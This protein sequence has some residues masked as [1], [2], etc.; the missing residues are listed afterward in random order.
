M[1]ALDLSRFGLPIDA[2]MGELQAR[3]ARSNGN[4][5]ATYSGHDQYGLAFRFFIFDK[6]NKVKSQ[7]AGVELYDPI[8]MIEIFIDRKTRLHQ[9]V[10]DKIRYRHEEEYQRFKEGREAPGTP[11]DKWGVIPSHE[12]ATLVKAGIFSVEQLA[13]QSA[14]RIQGKFPA[15]FFEHFQRA[16]QFVAAKTGRVEAEKMADKMLELQRG[17][18]EMMA[19]MS[20]LEEERDLLLQSG[21]Q[22]AV[23]RGRKPKADKKIITDADFEQ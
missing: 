12:I 2:D 22:P 7:L 20:K 18:A 9:K 8:E 21:N 14:D 23:K 15:V 4:G 16:Q 1:G 5:V 13:L 19:K 17:Y 11:L 6:Y 3:V 10:T